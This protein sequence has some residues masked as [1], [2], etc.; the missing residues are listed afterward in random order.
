MG[1]R[2]VA[3]K[4]GTAASVDDRTVEENERFKLK[5]SIESG[6]A[7]WIVETAETEVT[8]TDT[9]EWNLVMT[10]TPSEIVEGETESITVEIKA[11]PEEGEGDGCL[12]AD[13]FTFAIEIGGEALAGEDYTMEGAPEAGPR[14]STYAG[15]PTSSGRCR[16]RHCST[17]KTTTATPSRSHRW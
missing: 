16:S 4:T 14:P 1:R 11:T 2:Y 17:A 7:G 13:P 8:I 6:G 15:G 12:T 5:P 10:A 9:D 3:R